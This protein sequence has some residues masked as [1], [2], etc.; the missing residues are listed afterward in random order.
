[1]TP[2][3]CFRKLLI[4]RVNA[5][6][7]YESTSPGILASTIDG[8]DSVNVSFRIR[9]CHRTGLGCALFFLSFLL[10][11]LL[12]RLLFADLFSCVYCL[13][14][15]TRPKSNETLIFTSWCCTLWRLFFFRLIVMIRISFN[16]IGCA[17]A[18]NVIVINLTWSWMIGQAHIELL[19]AKKSLMNLR[20]AERCFSVTLTN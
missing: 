18:E 19:T 9:Q 1:M 17:Y 7:A 12:F 8:D 3:L 20:K 6:I 5:R 11:L 14:C 15:M 2:C 16:W 4:T 10:L 13:C